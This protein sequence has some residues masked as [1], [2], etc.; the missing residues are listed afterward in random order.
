[1]AV[2]EIKD[3]AAPGGGF[4]FEGLQ[5]KQVGVSQVGDV[6]VVAN[7]G[8]VGGGVVVAVDADGLATAEGDVENQGNEVGFRLVGFAAGDAVGAFGSSGHIEIAQ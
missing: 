4:G 1:M 8:A 2:S 5:G 7:A 6:D 3:Q